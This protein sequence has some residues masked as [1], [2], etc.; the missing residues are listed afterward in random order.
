MAETKESSTEKSV[1]KQELPTESFDAAFKGLMETAM[2]V[3]REVTDAFSMKKVVQPYWALCITKLYTS[4]IAAENPDGFKEMFRNFYKEYRKQLIEPLMDSDGMND[5]WLKVKEILPAPFDNDGK[6]RPKNLFG[7]P[8]ILEGLVLYF[9]TERKYRAFCIPISKVY[10]VACE[11]YVEME[12]EKSVHSP[13]PAAILYNFYAAF[14]HVCKDKDKK[15]ILKNVEV[16]K[17]IVVELSPEEGSDNGST[18]SPLKEMM[19]RFAKSSGMPLDDSG[20]M[21]EAIG[22]LFKPETTEKINKLVK[23]VTESF[24]AST[25]TNGVPDIDKVLSNIGTALQKP[26]LRDI[27]SEQTKNITN[28]QASIP[29]A[30]NPVGGALSPTVSPTSTATPASAASSITDASEQD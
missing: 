25:E 21:E 24:T 17:E 5:S 27:L 18:F 22:Q 28:L 19:K 8:E 9:Q 3:E 6:K 15:A 4:Y 26:E 7:A 11:H 20:K 30:E 14:L 13:L 2:Q 16:I 29:T 23:T 12:K 1:E 10:R